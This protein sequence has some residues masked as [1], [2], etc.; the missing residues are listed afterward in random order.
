MRAWFNRLS[1]F[2]VQLRETT[3]N[4]GANPSPECF[5]SMVYQHYNI[6]LSD[7]LLAKIREKN[8]NSINGTINTY[9]YLR[10]NLFSDFT[11][12]SVIPFDHDKCGLTSERMR[13]RIAFT[14]DVTW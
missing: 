11:A 9:K 4:I 1:L 7:D 3:L 2:L 5:R 10:E 8:S 12:F 6:S 14:D 13:R